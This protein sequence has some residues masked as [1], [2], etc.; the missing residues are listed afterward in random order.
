MA[1]QR[2]KI[3]LAFASEHFTL[4]SLTIADAS[5]RWAEWLNDPV[6]ARM[7]NAK[8]RSLG[9]PELRDYIL[10]FDQVSRLL[11]GIFDR[12]S[13]RHVGIATGHI[14]DDGLKIQPSVLI[15][16][17]EFRH[18]GAVSELADAVVDH[19]FAKLGFHAM[20][21]TILAHNQAAID[22]V[23]KRGWVMTQRLARAKKSFITGE[24]Y[25]VLVYEF[26]RETWLRQKQ[27]QASP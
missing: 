4:R 25:D 8:P 23:E 11:V 10:S 18:L 12:A 26:T 13:G 17:P 3:D 19:L 2:G 21:S 14:S 20:T 9:E 27:Q 5:R 24:V 1:V 22:L 7:L 6:A 16:E 15:G